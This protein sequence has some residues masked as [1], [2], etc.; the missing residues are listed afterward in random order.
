MLASLGKAV[1]V[2]HALYSTI[3]G[4]AGANTTFCVGTAAIVRHSAVLLTQ[5]SFYSAVDVGTDIFSA[6]QALG[7]LPT[8]LFGGYPAHLRAV[9]IVGTYGHSN[10]N[11]ASNTTV[12]ATVPL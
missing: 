5:L 7:C 1:G 12:G 4:Y 9:G 6:V 2:C 11:A 8:P 10:D 3:N